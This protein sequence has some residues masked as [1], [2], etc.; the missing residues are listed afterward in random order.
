MRY[1][2]K[3]EFHSELG[4]YVLSQG[5]YWYIR[6]H[7]IMY[8]YIVG[9]PISAGISC[10]ILKFELGY[11]IPSKGIYW[12]VLGQIQALTNLEAITLGEWSE[13]A[14]RSSKRAQFWAHNSLTTSPSTGPKHGPVVPKP[15]PC[16][17]AIL[18]DYAPS[19][20]YRSETLAGGLKR[21]RPL[22][23]YGGGV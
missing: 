19:A 7:P 1:G 20:F 5:M 11:C 17:K 21:D 9:H 22:R 8:W 4:Y 14:R 2:G 13:A 6:C 10:T 15:G 3:C 23:P 18:P 16:L 12:Y